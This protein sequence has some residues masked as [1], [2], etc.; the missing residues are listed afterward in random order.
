[1]KNTLSRLI[2]FSPFFSN[3]KLNSITLLPRS[4]TGRLASRNSTLHFIA[5]PQLNSSLQLLSRTTQKTQP[6]YCWE[7]VFAMP[8]QCNG[9]YSIVGWVFVAAGI[10]L[11]SPCL[12]MNVYSDFTVQAFGR[13]LTL[14]IITFSIPIFFIT[15]SLIFEVCGNIFHFI[16][17]LHRLLNKGL[18]SFR[19]VLRRVI[20]RHPVFQSR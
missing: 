16:F 1:M 7:D 12:A 5:P 18:P 10:Y 9:S 6:L 20:F 17:G 2:T 13:N 19:P 8:L 15:R 14:S 4:Y 11:Q 3:C